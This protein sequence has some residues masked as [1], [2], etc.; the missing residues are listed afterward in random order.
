[1]LL[2]AA[3]PDTRPNQGELNGAPTA[4]LNIA[5]IIISCKWLFI[6]RGELLSHALRTEH[7]IPECY[8]LTEAARRTQS[9]VTAAGDQYAL[10][11]RQKKHRRNCPGE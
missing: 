1:M 11:W 3:S 2:E 7:T 9:I 10:T 4:V 6:T 8:S 5:Q